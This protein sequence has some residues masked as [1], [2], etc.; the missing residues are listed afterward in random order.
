MTKMYA[1]TATVSVVAAYMP[2]RGAAWKVPR[3]RK[4]LGSESRNRGLGGLENMNIS[5]KAWRA[6]MPLISDQDI[7]IKV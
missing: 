1:V 7:G 5:R 4:E 3:K 2:W 6:P